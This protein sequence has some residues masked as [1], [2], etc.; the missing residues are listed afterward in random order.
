MTQLLA[1]ELAVLF[2]P[3]SGIVYSQEVPKHALDDKTIANYRDM[4]ARYGGFVQKPVGLRFVE[5]KKY[6]DEG[7]PGFSMARPLFELPDAPVFFGLQIADPECAD[8]NLKHLAA[9]K[10]LIVLDLCGTRVSAEG[11]KELAPLTNLS[12]LTLSTLI[13][14]RTRGLENGF[15]YLAPLKNLRAL[16]L[17]TASVTDKGLKELAK[18][19]SL[20]SLELAATQI[21]DAGVKHL[22]ALENLTFL[23]VSSTKITDAGLKELAPLK[24]L[25][26][27]W[28]GDTKADVLRRTAGPLTDAGLKELT[29]FPNLTDLYYGSTHVTDKGLEDVAKLRNLT[30]L[31]LYRTNVTEAGLAK[32]RKALPKCKI[33]SYKI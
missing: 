8:A 24:N 21:T 32:L 22:A 18:L 15:K 20:A 16:D 6:A 4:A 33:E 27:L 26:K 1:L 19:T 23:D 28:V 11:L 9:L 2:V 13:L 31:F 5:G 3:V 17:D 25:T 14:P 29:A 10:H 12:A 30:S 7:L